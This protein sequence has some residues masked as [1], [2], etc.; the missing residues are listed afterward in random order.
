MGNT[1]GRIP[2]PCVRNC[3]LDTDDTCLGCF[4][5]LQEILRWS[6]ADNQGR[7][8]ILESAE[9]RRVVRAKKLG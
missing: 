7:T 4:R 8:L 3:C 5:S 9:R 6:A 2:S 1:E